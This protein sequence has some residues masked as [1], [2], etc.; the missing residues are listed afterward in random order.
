MSTDIKW[1]VTDED[2]DEKL[3]KQRVKRQARQLHIANAGVPV[4]PTRG[5]MDF[6]K[7]TKTS[8]VIEDVRQGR[9]VCTKC[10]LV[11][12]TALSD[13]SE[14]RNFGDNDR[15]GADPNRVG[16]VVDY[17][18]EN[19]LGTAVGTTDPNNRLAKTQITNVQDASQRKLLVAFKKI[20][21]NAERMSLP[22]DVQRLAQELFKQVE[23]T[24]FMK[25]R[26]VDTLVA[27]CIYIAAKACRADRPLKELCAVLNVKRRHVSRAYSDV[28]RL[29]A[30]SKLK[31][32]KARGHTAHRQSAAE[33]FIERYVKNL[34]LP[35]K[36]ANVTRQVVKKIQELSLMG[37]KQPSTIAASA[38]YLVVA[39]HKNVNRTFKEIATVAGISDSTIQQAY[40]KFVYDHRGK[41]VPESYVTKEMVAS[42]PAK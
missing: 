36:L 41:L 38:L 33:S 40:K 23:T 32:P 2:V 34:K 15:R 14:W 26:K 35:S 31:L 28:M 13:G 39:L 5:C 29:K 37:G 19:D 3:R 17:L 30:E 11:L 22:E 24:G 20:R 8:N 9:Y 27:T 18:N 4:C 12:G 6:Y 1:K 42:L 25:G 7:R 16:H 10:G 21:Q